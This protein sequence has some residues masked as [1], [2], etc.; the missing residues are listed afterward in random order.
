MQSQSIYIIIVISL[1]YLLL[2]RHFEISL[3]I[4]VSI[5]W[6]RKKMKHNLSLLITFLHDFPVTTYCY[7][8]VVFFISNIIYSLLLSPFCTLKDVAFFIQISLYTF[9]RNCPDLNDILSK[10]LLI[11]QIVTLIRARAGNGNSSLQ[12]P[13]PHRMA[14]PA[15]SC[16]VSSCIC[17][18]PTS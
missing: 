15:R 6:F 7:R 5:L 16:W 9:S 2:M 1:S 12:V 18:S 14:P 4:Y 10:Q 13:E 3:E 8:Y 11:H 17:D